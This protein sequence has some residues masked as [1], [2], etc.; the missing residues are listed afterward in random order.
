MEEVL[1]SVFKRVSCLEGRALFLD[2]TLTDNEHMG[3]INEQHRGKSSPTNVLS[4]PQYPCLK[5]IPPQGPLLLGDLVFSYGK[6][7]QEAREH[8]VPF[9]EHFAHLIVHGALH[10]LGWDHIEEEEAKKME[11]LETQILYDLGFSDPY[12]H[13][14]GVPEKD[15][16]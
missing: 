7:A 12:A 6:I 4:F 15:M 8:A 10:L 1:Y 11:A 14:W 9:Q 3:Q 5:T 13:G 2:I 16:S